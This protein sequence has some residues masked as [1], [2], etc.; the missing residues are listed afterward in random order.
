MS[1]PVQKSPPSL[2][3]SYDSATWEKQIKTNSVR[4]VNVIIVT[5]IYSTLATLHPTVM[6]VLPPLGIFAVGPY[7]VGFEECGSCV[8]L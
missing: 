4:H 1:V 6:G 3:A 2:L 5:D 8:G 7:G